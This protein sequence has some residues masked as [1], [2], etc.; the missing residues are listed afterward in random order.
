MSMS[1]STE[2][3]TY[4]MQIYL[5]LWLCVEFFLL[6]LAKLVR[7]VPEKGASGVIV[8]SMIGMCEE[9]RTN[10]SGFAIQPLK[11][12][13]CMPQSENIFLTFYLGNID[14]ECKF[15]KY[16]GQDLNSSLRPH[17]YLNQDLFRGLNRFSNTH[18]HLCLC[19]SKG[20]C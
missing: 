19:V 10:R 14:W 2:N 15:N 7:S 11:L 6:K 20:Y 5:L 3:L 17:R 4:L 18:P 8:I 16:F 13:I 1:Y 12:V 9:G